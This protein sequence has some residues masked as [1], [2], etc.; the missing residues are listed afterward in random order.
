MGIGDGGRG[1]RDE[2]CRL[3]RYEHKQGGSASL[4][5]G[6]Y[7]RTLDVNHGAFAVDTDNTTTAFT[8]IT[9]GLFADLRVPCDRMPTLLNRRS[10]RECTECELLDLANTK[11]CW[12][13]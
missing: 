8:L 2:F 12:L 13:S 7:Q 6:A 5:I 4:I 1:T 3:Q 10:L 11:L 9:P